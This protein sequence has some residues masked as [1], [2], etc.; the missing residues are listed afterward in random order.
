MK[1]VHAVSMIGGA[2]CCEAVRS[3]KGQRLL[4]AQGVRLPLKACTMSI[5]CK[6]R[7]QK[8][9]DRRAEDR[10]ALGSTHRG[11]LFGISERRKAEEIGRAHV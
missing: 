8:H 9:S 1:D 7:Y 2:P 5:Q 4:V 10:R 3:L 11:S 6:C